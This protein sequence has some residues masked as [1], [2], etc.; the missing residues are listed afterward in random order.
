MKRRWHLI[1]VAVPSYVPGGFVRN[2]DPALGITSL[3]VTPNVNEAM[4]F[5]SLLEATD[6]LES[7]LPTIPIAAD[8]TPNQ[9]L[10][11]FDVIVDDAD[12]ASF[13]P[14]TS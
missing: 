1:D 6:L 4:Q 5:Q 8:G 3:V 9:P 2:Y 7:V 14:T 11:L 12:S 13:V 10:A